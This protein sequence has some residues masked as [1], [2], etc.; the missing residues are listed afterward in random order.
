MTN[1][2]ATRTLVIEREMPHPPEK[3]WRA[4]TQGPLIEEWLMTNDFQP[5]VGHRFTFRSTPV[6][7]WNGIIDS[8]VLVVEPNSRLSYSWASMGLET[9]VTWT[10]TPTQRRHASP[11]GAIRLPVGRGCQLQGC[12]VGMDEVHRQPGACRWRV[13]LIMKAKNDCLL[14]DDHTHSVFYR[15]RRRCADRAISGQPPWRSALAWLPNVLLRHPGSLESAWGHCHPCAALSAAQ[16]MGVCRHLLRPDRRGRVLRC[17]WR[18]RRL[19]LS[20][21]RPSRPY[22]AYCGIVGTSTGKPYHRRPLPGE[23]WPAGYQCKSSVDCLKPAEIQQ[24]GVDVGR[25]GSFR[26]RVR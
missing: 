22:W 20:R 11:H 26:S 13:G 16:G 12:D 19:R 17:G 4:L 24:T 2:A 1:T 5:V 15:K 10:L 23:E 3:I 18:L 7:G 25:S 14:D 21:H 8:E 9:V 6:Q